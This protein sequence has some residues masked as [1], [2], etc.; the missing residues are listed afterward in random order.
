MKI[1]AVYK[2]TTLLVI[3]SKDFCHIRT[4]CTHLV[5]A[6]FD[7]QSNSKLAFQLFNHFL[8][9]KRKSQIISVKMTKT[10]RRDLAYR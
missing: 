8:V 9:N 10:N 5:P 3:A 1:S 6:S 7:E 2:G 4:L